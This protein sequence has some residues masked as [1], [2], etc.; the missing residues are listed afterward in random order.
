MR[1]AA[2]PGNNHPDA[3]LVR[4]AGKTKHALRRA[5]RRY[6]GHFEGDLQQCQYIRRFLHD[7]LIGIRTHDDGYHNSG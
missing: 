2:S 1:G 4:L 6:D 3:A 5:V 7:R